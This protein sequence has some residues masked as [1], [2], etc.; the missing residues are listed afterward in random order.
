MKRY[1]FALGALRFIRYFIMGHLAVA[2]PILLA[3]TVGAVAAGLV[4]SAAGLISLAASIAYSALGD[5]VGHARGLAI[6][7]AAFA[8]AVAALAYIR[9]PWLMAAALGL[10]GIGMLGPGATR[11]AFVPLIS[12][13]VRDHSASPVERTQALGVISAISTVGGMIGSATAAVYP[14]QKALVPYAVASFA[15]AALVAAL[16]GA[17]ERIRPVNPFA[18]IGKR[19]RVVAG[20]SLSQFVAGIGVGLSMPLLSLWLHAYMGLGEGAIGVIFAAGN[21]AFAAASLVA[22]KLARALGLVKASAASRIAAGALLASLVLFKD[23]IAFAAVYMVYNAFVGIGGAARSSY[24]V[25]A[26]AE[27]SEATTQAV[28]SIAIRASSI[29]SVAL[30]GYLIDIEPALVMPIAGALSIASG[31]IFLYTLRE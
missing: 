21:G 24:I 30:S 6:S 7:E 31:L 17:R 11:G 27:G 3:Q 8:S 25:G 18:G 29:P 22:Y 19:A 4:L 15:A 2:L 9:S 20:Y 23:P 1:V 26:A 14:I 5:V 12:A 10:G 28:T 13:V 16:L